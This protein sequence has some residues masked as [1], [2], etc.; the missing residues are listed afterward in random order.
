MGLFRA[1][2]ARTV[3]IERRTI[4]RYRVDLPA[5]IETMSGTRDCVMSDISVAGAKITMNDP[6]PIGVSGMLCWDGQEV[7]CTVVWSK[8]GACGVDFER[9]ISPML[10]DGVSKGIIENSGPVADPNRI[11]LGRKRA[12]IGSVS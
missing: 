9:S 6:L 4:Q 1:A 7:F 11:P 12:R 3:N 8:D 5:T 10:I 2:N